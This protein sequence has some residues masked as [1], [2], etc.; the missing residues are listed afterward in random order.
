VESSSNI[1][2]VVC[3]KD[4][5]TELKRFWES[6]DRQTLLPDELIIVD[7]SEYDKISGLIQNRIRSSRYLIKYIR[8]EPDL[9]RQRNTG[10]RES[11]GKYIFFFDDD[12]ILDSEFIR[13]IYE[14]FSQFDGQKIGG[15]TGRIE[16]TSS[17]K[18]PIDFLDNLFKKLFFL[19]GQG[20]G[21]LKLSGFPAHRRD[22]ELAFV[23][24]LPGGCTAYAKEVFSRYSFDENLTEYAY[25]EDVDFSCRVSKEYKLLYQPKA[26]LEHLAT[27]F[28]TAD[29]K[30]LRRMMVRNHFY[31]FR[32]NIP[33]DS[34]HIFG[35]LMSLLG[36]ILY[37]A[38]L[39]KDIKACIG[40]ANGLIS[41]L[42]LSQNV[43][44]E[45]CL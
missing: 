37:N 16:N 35:F 7:A 6:L 41:P 8:T 34:R 1:T 15:I 9:T 12:V 40:I 3:T 4:R 28:K 39:V 5:F 31:L 20:K 14:T 38:I 30:M 45:K 44:K 22:D 17:E 26:K 24:V 13:V 11:R 2:V 33:K 29:S 43:K 23:E 18:N 21:T 19:T 36:L 32:K 10:I 42:S 27:T 25:M